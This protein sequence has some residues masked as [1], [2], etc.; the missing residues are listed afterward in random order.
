MEN[1]VIQSMPIGYALHQFVCDENGKPVDYI[2]IDLNPQ[3]EHFTGLKAEAVIGKRVLEVIP[4]TKND[5]FNWIETYARVAFENEKIKIEQFSQALNR[6]YRVIAYSPKPGYFVTLIEDISDEKEM[7]RQ[8]NQSQQ[9]VKR[10]QIML[11]IYRMDVQDLQSFLDYILES[12]LIMLECE[13]GYIF[14]YSE[15]NQE[16]TIN[17]WTKGVM[18]DCQIFEP[19]QIYALEDTGIWGDVVRQRKP[20]IVNHFAQPHPLKKGYPKGHVPVQRYLSIPVFFNN[21]IVAAV[22]LANRKAEFSDFD[23]HQLTILMQSAWYIYE[24][25][26]QMKHNQNEQLRFN[27]ILNKVPI[28]FCEFDQ[29]SR[30]TYVNNQYCNYFQLT[31]D[32]L[33]GKPFLDLIPKKYQRQTKQRYLDLTPTNPAVIDIHRVLVNN[34][35]RWMEWQNVAIFDGNGQVTTYF[36]IGSDVTER[37]LLDEK[38]KEELAQLRAAFEDHR[39]VMI[40][41]EPDSGKLLYANPAAADFYGYTQQ[42]LLTLKFQDI[43]MLNKE[44]LQALKQKA[45]NQS[46]QFYTLPQR[47]KD[48]EIRMVDIFSSPIQYED[49]T[50]LFSIIFDVTEKEQAM[51]EIKYLAYHDHLKGVYN[52]RYFEESFEKLNK[53]SHQPLAIIIGDINGLKMVNDSYGHLGG[54]ALIQA[55]IKEIQTLIPLHSMLA[56]IGGDEFAILI[57]NTNEQDVLNLTNLLEKELEKQIEV[58]VKETMQLYL[59]VSFGYGIQKDGNESLDDIVKEAE[60]HIYRRKHYHHKSIRSHMIKAMMSTLFQKSERELHHSQRVGVYSELLARR[61]GWDLDRLNR[62]KAAGS[63]HDIGK[64]GIAEAILNKPGPL[65]DSEWELLK[66][67]PLKSARILEE[68]EEYR[69]I[70]KFVA[71]HHERWDGKGYPYGWKEDDIPLEARIIAIADAYDAMTHYR[72]Y[73]AAMTQEEA[74]KEIIRCAGTQFDPMLAKLFVEEVLQS[75]FEE[76]K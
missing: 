76:D 54:D 7:E 69:D 25:K 8:F 46:Q 28:L 42:E 44:A 20:I 34:K 32:Q 63:L 43:N 56:R 9:I 74:I 29:E 62:I 71:S 70:T 37:I 26:I 41:I 33:I 12:A 15:K 24:S 23:V 21:E 18:P 27:Q 61:L 22:G 64:I 73:R 47:L 13:Y 45:L 65:D 55:A 59:S 58:Q 6:W 52:R 51:E 66:Q 16:F 5:P 17:A 72:T 19:K 3:F 40:F 2:F 60:N 50:I 75:V 10:Q 11:D 39:A 53:Q 57:H 30:L 35:L 4:E 1:K 14:T 36:G 49:K 31:Q 67:H 68:I 48:G 38:N